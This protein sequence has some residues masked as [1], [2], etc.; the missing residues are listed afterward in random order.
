MILSHARCLHLRSLY[1]DLGLGVGTTTHWTEERA[2]QAPRHPNPVYQASTQDRRVDLVDL[3]LT[4]HQSLGTQTMR[5]LLH[6]H[7]R[8]SLTLHHSQDHTVQHLCMERLLHLRTPTNN[9]ARTL[10]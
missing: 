4:V 10:Q 9:E 1:T 5:R 6:H 2:Q 8:V 7:C 3:D